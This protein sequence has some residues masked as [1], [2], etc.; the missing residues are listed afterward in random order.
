VSAVSRQVDDDRPIPYV[1]TDAAINPGNSGGPLVDIAGDLVGINTFIRSESGG[2][3]GLGFT[4][5][6]ALVALAF[7]QL[8]DYGHLHRA[9]T[10][11]S[12]QNVTP[13][14][15]A[16]L[17]LDTDTGLIIANVLAESPAES[18][19]IKVGDVITAIDGRR[20][21]NLS[22]ADFYLQVMS[23]QDGQSL[24]LTLNRDG[25]VTSASLTAVA[26]PHD[27]T[28][29]AT[30]GS[31]AGEFV[32]PLGVLASAIPPDEVEAH[33]GGWG[34]MVTARV[35]TPSFDDAGL[36]PGDVVRSVN[37]VAVTSVGGLRSA[38]ERVA[39]GDAVVLQVDRGG[40]LSFI[41]FTRE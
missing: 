26:V 33:G 36:A 16:G 11:L 1:Q 28:R 2:S 14:L 39:P 7:P 13:E 27:C 19:G 40:R 23:L 8:R 29:E 20:L 38:V 35:A 30:L 9:V 21:E 24:N 5:P 41:A 15:K 4:L 37:K 10:G 18:A 6:G 31:V 22:L 32:E 17:G 34:V 12:V 3:E 25:L